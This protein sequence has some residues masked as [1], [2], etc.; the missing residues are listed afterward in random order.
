[1]IDL[2]ARAPDGA[3]GVHDVEA[4]NAYRT[5][6][7]VFAFAATAAWGSHDV[8]AR[9]DRTVPPTA[10]AAPAFPTQYP[11]LRVYYGGAVRS[12]CMVAVADAPTGDTPMVRKN[13]TTYAVYLVDTTDPN[14]SSVRLRTNDGTKAIRLLT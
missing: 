12:L 2:I 8:F 13:G 4:G 3:S 9:P 7:A 11:G 5:A 14:A 1:M 10:V 6:L